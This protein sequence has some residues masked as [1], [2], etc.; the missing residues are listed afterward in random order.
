M[1]VIFIGGYK[2]PPKCLN[3]GNNKQSFPLTLHIFHETTSAAVKIY[4]PEEIP[5]AEFLNRINTW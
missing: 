1:L 4:F 5:A 2:L 3:P